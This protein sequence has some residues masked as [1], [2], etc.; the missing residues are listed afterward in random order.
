MLAH[1]RLKRQAGLAEANPAIQALHEAVALGKRA[2][3]L[4]EAM[5]DQAEIA[6]ARRDLVTDVAVDDPE[7]QPRGGGLQI[8]FR[9]TA[10]GLVGIDA[11]GALVEPYADEL[12]DHF[13]RMLKIGIHQHRR[14]GRACCIDAG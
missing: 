8:S 3:G 5:I 10:A 2:Q 11:V 7:E 14:I 4:H 9:R 13:R 6:G 12:A 1:R